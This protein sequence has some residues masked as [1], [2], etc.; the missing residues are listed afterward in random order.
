[1][2]VCTISTSICHEC[3]SDTNEMSHT[4]SPR[5]EYAGH[6]PYSKTSGVG[7]LHEGVEYNGYY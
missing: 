1:M 7:G 6:L 4:T 3:E 5:L 2:L